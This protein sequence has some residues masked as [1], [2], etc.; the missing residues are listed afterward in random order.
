MIVIFGAIAHSH[1]GVTATELGDPVVGVMKAVN[2]VE[3]IVLARGDKLEELIIVVRSTLDDHRVFVVSNHVLAAPLVD[4]VVA[5]LSG[6]MRIQGPQ[7]VRVDSMFV[8]S[9]IVFIC[10]KLRESGL[11]VYFVVDQEG[12]VVQNQA[13]FC[14]DLEHQSS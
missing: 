4:Y 9:N 6:W 12:V 3:P 2:V 5:A 14:L 10:P 11:M 1:S 8:A 13:I 7:L